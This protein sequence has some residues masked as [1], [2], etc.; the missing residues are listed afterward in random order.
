MASGGFVSR[1]EA[2]GRVILWRLPQQL[3]VTDW[4][5]LHPTLPA[6]RLCWAFV[7]VL[8]SGLGPALPENGARLRSWAAS[9]RCDKV[10]QPGTVVHTCGPSAGDAE[11]GGSPRGQGSLGS[12]DSENRGKTTA[13]A[14][15]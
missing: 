7:V 10:K 13:G 6:S 8:S 2:L 15:Y 11:A 14:F 3:A 5:P 1:S 9:E 12:I 4:G